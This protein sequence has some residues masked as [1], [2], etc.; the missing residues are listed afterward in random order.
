MFTRSVPQGAGYATIAPVASQIAYLD[1][2]VDKMIQ[3][4]PE[5]RFNTVEEIKK[6]LIGRRN[7]FVSLQELDSKRREVVPASAPPLFEPI[8][9]MAI[10]DWNSGTLLLQL[11]R[12][13]EDGWVRR[14]QSPHGG[15]NS[16]SGAQTTDFEF[17]GDETYLRVEELRAQ[18]FIDYFKRYLEMA[19]RGY[20][21]DLKSRAQQQEIDKREKLQQ[22]IAAAETR[23]R[24]LEKLKI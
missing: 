19:N 4:K 10:D 21:Q 2:L 3:H 13:P 16:I 22:E 23:A 12:A 8:K 20:E 1:P 9:L 15:Y 24:V 7:E 5:A 14:F 11:N 17:Q 6:E 18:V